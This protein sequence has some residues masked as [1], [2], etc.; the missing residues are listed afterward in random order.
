[1]CARAHRRAATGGN[2][3][4]ADAI[5]HSRGT[6]GHPHPGQPGLQAPRVQGRAPAAETRLPGA[7]DD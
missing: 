1:M 2:H 3:L 4:G 5:F 7:G 6:G